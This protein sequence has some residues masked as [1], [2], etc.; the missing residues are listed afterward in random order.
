MPDVPANCMHFH[1]PSSIYIRNSSHLLVT[2]SLSFSFVFLRFSFSSTR[3]A[4]L[5]FAEPSDRALCLGLVDVQGPWRLPLP[6]LL[7]FPCFLIA[8]SETIH[9]GTPALNAKRAQVEGYGLKARVGGG[10]GG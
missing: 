7:Q 3:E 6:S 8:F 5:L 4:K 2:W 9:K 1:P 10:G